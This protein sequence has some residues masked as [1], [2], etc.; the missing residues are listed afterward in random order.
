MKE[1][2]EQQPQAMPS[3]EEAFR[4]KVQ[5]YS[6]CFI[7]NCPLKE[8]CLHWLVGQYADPMP[9]VQTSMNPR[10]P[11][12]GGENCEKFRPNV[13]A[14][15]KKGMTRFYLDM[16]GRVEHNIRQELIWHFGRTQY[17]E[18]RKGLR[19]ISPED[20]EVIAAVCRSPGWD[21]PF[22]YDGEQEDWLW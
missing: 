18:I 7:E 17:F 6:V 14:V 10:N 11:K 4:E 8:Q 22:V 19:L 15:M 1:K 21:G 3:Q 12:I 20:Q 16:P 5:H 9:F 13:R 2:K